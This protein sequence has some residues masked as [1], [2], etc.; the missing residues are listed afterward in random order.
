VNRYLTQEGLPGVAFGLPA[1]VLTLAIVGA[2]LLALV[3][4][5]L[6]AQRAASLP[7]RQAMGD[8]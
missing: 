6:P 7:A 2:T 3:A 8:R 1:A 5:T 4:G